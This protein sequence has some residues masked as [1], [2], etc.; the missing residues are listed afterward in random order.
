M[1]FF[2]G[3]FICVFDMTK[4]LSDYSIADSSMDEP[5]EALEERCDLSDLA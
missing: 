5:R 1:C 4:R 3:D 2:R